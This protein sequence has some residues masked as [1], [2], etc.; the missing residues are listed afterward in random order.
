MDKKRFST[1]F[2]LLLFFQVGYSQADV[3]DYNTIAI[4]PQ[5][6]GGI[7]EFMKFVITNY[8]IPEEDDVVTGVLEVA[9]IIDSKGKVT[10]TTIIQ[11][12]GNAGNEVKRILSNCPKWIPGKQD[13]IDVATRYTFPVTIK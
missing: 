2:L 13:G 12:V 11:D 1:V 7:S 6:P 10:K 9:I 8:Q 4:K 5:F 3:F